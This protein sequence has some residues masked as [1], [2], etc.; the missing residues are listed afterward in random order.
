MLA[1][2]TRMV[3]DYFNIKIFHALKYRR[4]F[5]G[6]GLLLYHSQQRPFRVFIHSQEFYLFRPS[7]MLSSIYI[8]L[9][10]GMNRYQ[11]VEFLFRRTIFEKTTERKQVRRLN[12]FFSAEYL[13]GGKKLH[14]CIS[15]VDLSWGNALHLGLTFLGGFGMDCS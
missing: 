13:K 4:T 9:E 6:Q 8:G 15:F 1:P 5:K 10:N 14:N 11:Q 2:V 3:S 12:T 7:S